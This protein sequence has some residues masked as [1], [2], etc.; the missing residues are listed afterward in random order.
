MGWLWWCIGTV[1]FLFFLVLLIA[2][3]CF[4]RVFYFKSRKELGDDEFEIPRGEI[5]EEFRDV[6][7]GWAKTARKLPHE[8]IEIESFDGLKLRGR[9]YEYKAGAAIELMFHGYEG[10]SE[11]DLSGGIERC[12]ALKRNALLIDQRGSG[13]SDGH[14]SS[15]GINER[16]DCKSWVEYAIKRFGSDVK[17]GLTGVSMGAATVIMATEL[18]LPENVKFVLADC[19]Y[20]SAK[21]ILL[22]VISEMKLPAKAIYPFVKLGAKIFGGFDLEESSPIEAARKCQIPIIF[23][24]GDADAF[25]PFEM[26]ERM[27]NEC[28]CEKK[29]LL[30]IENAGHGLAYPVAPQKYIDELKRFEA[31]L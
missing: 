28:G 5:Y 6:M 23:V 20:S 7:I 11:R 26:S 14:I 2:F 27:Y 3:I 29:R 8:D 24:H 10:D 18:D 12:F 19:G 15:F 16:R 1:V 4:M 17:L 21:E 9:Y 31:E 30:K 13:R 22:K 25:V